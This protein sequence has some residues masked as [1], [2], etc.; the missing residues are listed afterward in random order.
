[1]S[2]VTTSPLSKLYRFA[3]VVFAFGVIFWIGGSL[4]RAL[5][6]NEFYIPGTVEYD[7]SLTLDEEFQ[8]FNLVSS[9]SIVVLVAYGL[10]LLSS[11]YLIAK[12]P[13]KRKENG[14]LIL[15]AILFYLFVPVELFTAYLDIEY[16]LLWDRAMSEFAKL[17]VLS[18]L[19][20]N[21]QLKELLSHRVSAL[22]GVPIIA[23]LC[24]Y[25]AIGVLVWQPMK[26]KPD[27][28]STPA[29]PE[30]QTTEQ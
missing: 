16:L 17:D 25:T 9:S 10:V 7:T 6:A 14:W 23:M 4:I 2:Q 21:T 3:L 22:S 18:I 12:F 26:K 24:Y 29:G 20:Y 13:G 11:I 30:H 19:S 27:Q 8:L 5:I 28:S 15:S 1:M